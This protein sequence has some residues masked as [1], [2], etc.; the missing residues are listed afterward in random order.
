M[1][2]SIHGTLRNRDANSETKTCNFVQSP[3]ENARTHINRQIE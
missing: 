3:Y 2:D 1:N